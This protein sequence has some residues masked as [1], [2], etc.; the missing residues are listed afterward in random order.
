MPVRPGSPRRPGTRSPFPGTG[1][2]EP[3]RLSPGSPGTS[4]GAVWAAP[5]RSPGGR[6]A[7]CVRGERCPELPSA[8]RT[9]RWRRWGSS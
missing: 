1:V 7:V 5:G 3:K 9:G 4:P 8:A 2:S 6:A